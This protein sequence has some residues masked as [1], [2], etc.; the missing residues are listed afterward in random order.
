MITQQKSMP[1]Y[2]YACKACG[3][4]FEE[5]QKMS[6]PPIDEC[7]KCGQKS[8]QRLISQGNFILKGGGWYTTGGYGHP[9]K[10]ADDSSSSSGS[11]SSSKSDTKTETKTDAKPAGVPD[12]ALPPALKGGGDGGGSSTSPSSSGPR[13]G[14]SSSQAA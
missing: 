4:Q 13:N 2:E 14:G 7:P 11:S 6:D 8:A 9:A 5:I 3:H 12:A 1:T 10:K